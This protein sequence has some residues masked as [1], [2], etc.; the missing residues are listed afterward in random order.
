MLVNP[1][2]LYNLY[3]RDQSNMN[4]NDSDWDTIEQVYLD[5]E[6]WFEAWR[7]QVTTYPHVALRGTE[8]LRDH[9]H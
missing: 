8:K 1:I 4:Y 3:Q 9:L 6:T 2:I 5:D 7:N